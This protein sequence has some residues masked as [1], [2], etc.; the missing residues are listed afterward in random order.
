MYSAP[1]SDSKFKHRASLETR[2]K[3]EPSIPYSTRP[4]FVTISHE[5]SRIVSWYLDHGFFLSKEIQGSIPG[6]AREAKSN[7]ETL[8]GGTFDTAQRVT[9]LGN[10]WSSYTL[11][12]ITNTVNSVVEEVIVEAGKNVTLNCPGVTEDSLVLMLEWKANGMRLLEY[13]SSTTTVWNHQNRVSLSSKNYALQFHPVTS[14]DS[15]KYECLVNSRNTAEAVVELIVRG[16]FLLAPCSGERI[17]GFGLGF[18]PRDRELGDDFVQISGR[19]YAGPP[20]RR[21]IVMGQPNCLCTETW[22]RST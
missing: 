22:A 11:A 1:H 17:A 14:A 19:D 5:A 12:R 3:C 18:E 7:K 8:Y 21:K 16:T 2:V 4:V 20:P 13:S 15:G 9:S 10:V 6:C